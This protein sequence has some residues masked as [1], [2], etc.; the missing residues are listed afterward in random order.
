[1]LRAII[2]SV[3]TLIFGFNSFGQA[4][5][6]NS[7]FVHRSG[8]F[9]EDG[10]NNTIK[11]EGVNLGGWLMWEGWIWNGGFT[12]QKTIFN[13][14][15]NK[16]GTTAAEAFRDSVYWN[17]IS[18]EDIAQIADE[19]FNVVRIPI[20]HEL[21]EEDLQPYVYKPEG[22]RVLDSVLEWCERYNVYAILDM[23]S[24]PGG[25]SWLFTADPDF[26]IYLWNG[27]IN[28]NR[29]IEL[30]KA[31]ADRYKDRGIIAGYDI[32]NEPDP[33][34]DSLMINL[35]QEIIDSIRTVDNNHMIIL[36][37]SNYAADFSSFT[38]LLD[39]N[40][41][42][43]FHLYTWFVSDI[44]AAIQPFTDLSLNSNV[45]IW[46]GEWGENDYAELDTTLSLFR[47]PVFGLSGSAF[48]TWKKTQ[49]E[50]AENYYLSVDTTSLWNKSIGW[51]CN[52]SLPEPTPVEMQMGIDEFV[53]NMKWGNCNFDDTLSN[54]INA[55]QLSGIAEYELLGYT[56]YPNPSQ[57]NFTIQFNNKHS[58]IDVRVVNAVGQQIKE[59]SC[60]NCSRINL[61]IH[62]KGL[63][64]LEISVD[65]HPVYNERV[66]VR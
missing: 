45:P 61:N 52:N 53:Q 60:K 38:S 64:F 18:E 25:Q 5:W 33:S 41:M 23:H 62:N 26:L 43:E 4:V 37:G 44:A 39:Q 12:Q 36:E 24:A 27:N 50:S 65:D 19:C 11:L 55:C 58:I 42:Y 1:M 28:K 30:W 7:S 35:Y 31:I 21:L 49:K 56:L 13:A 57:G 10:Q 3:V 9:V 14:I 48:W 20:N 47:D 59:M 66:I 22:W 46:C 40:M 2:I 29:T 16:L 17:Y 32:L 6:D 34:D 63:H 15:E 51:I 8:R 54:I